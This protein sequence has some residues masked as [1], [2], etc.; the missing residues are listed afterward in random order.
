VKR[1]LLALLLCACMSE[2]DYASQRVVQAEFAARMGIGYYQC[3]N[4][5]HS[6]CDGVLAGRPVTFR[7]STESC[8]WQEAR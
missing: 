1:A 3:W 6:V 8:W 5:E 4:G 2:E 7:C